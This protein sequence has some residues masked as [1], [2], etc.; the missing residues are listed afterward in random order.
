LIKRIAMEMGGFDTASHLPVI[1]YFRLPYCDELAGSCVARYHDD[2]KNSSS[3]KTMNELFGASFDHPMG[4]IPIRLNNLLHS[5]QMRKCYSADE[6]LL[7]HTLFW[8]YSAFIGQERRN[9]AFQAAMFGGEKTKAFRGLHAGMAANTTLKYCPKCLADD[10]V[11]KGEGYWRVLHQVPGMLTCPNHGLQLLDRCPSCEQKMIREREK[12]IALNEYCTCGNDLAIQ[13]TDAIP[14][15]ISEKCRDYQKDVLVLLNTD[16]LFEPEEMKRIYYD[17]LVKAGFVNPKGE[18]KHS[19]LVKDFTAFYGI[20]YLAHVNSSIEFDP[21][22][23][24]WLIAMFRNNEK[25]AHTLRQLL[26]IRFLFGSMESFMNGYLNNELPKAY[27]SGMESK[28][29]Y[30]EK[31]DAKLYQLVAKIVKEHSA[32]SLATISREIGYNLYYGIDKLPKTKAVIERADKVEYFEVDVEIS[33]EIG[34]CSLQK[35]A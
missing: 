16:I 12:L 30:W 4:D 33:F 19:Q 24:D 14:A 6:F 20:D 29:R 22:R 21:Y 9:I 7:Q 35:V 17:K 34:I 3:Y 15:S 13:Y 32:A 11:G 31:K 1:A 28:S 26:V 25:P 8:F 10:L 2:V 27:Y 5:T 18:I 23:A